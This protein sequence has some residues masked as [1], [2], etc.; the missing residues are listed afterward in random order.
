MPAPTPPTACEPDGAIPCEVNGETPPSAG[1]T[2][3]ETAR[4]G[5]PASVSPDR[6]LFFWGVGC[7]HCEEAKPFVRSLPEKW[8]GLL[9]EWIEVRRDSRGRARFARIV[10]ELSIAGAG[11]PAFIHGKRYVIG[12]EPGVTEE[13]VRSLLRGEREGQADEDLTLVVPLVGRLDPRE[14]SL[15]SLTIVIGLLDG[16]NPCAMW[17]LL[18]LMGILM[19]VRSR[20]R[21]L[22][23]GGLF[24]GMSGIVYFLFM[25]VW[26]GFFELAGLSRGVT[27]GLGVLALVMG[28]V[29]LKELVAF[30]WGVSLTIPDRVK[31]AL[32]RRMRSIAT[33]AS[34]PAAFLGV[35]ALAFL[36]NLVEL[37]CTL[38]L[39]AIYARILTLRL[40]QPLARAAY[41]ALYNLA[42]VSPLAVIVIVYAATLHRLTLGERGARWLKALSGVLLI[43]FGLLFLLRPEWLG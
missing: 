32:Y 39:P 5:Q 41:L 3:D 31:P 14:M 38:G 17:V 35:A 18:V 8:P 34:G 9:V 40:E 27:L 28:L 13:R 43:G 6:L 26:V 21:L 42:Y 25:T 24:V 23:V 36:V 11:I 7:S 12:F 20:R 19:H 10:R 30:R 29:N 4:A 1:S 15:S 22:W 33:A 16:V 2:S 37:G